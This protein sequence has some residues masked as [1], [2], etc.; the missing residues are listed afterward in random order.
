M[1]I[2][3]A[4][5]QRYQLTIGTGEDETVLYNA[6]KETAA[7]GALCIWTGRYDTH[8]G[9]KAGTIITLNPHGG[10]AF[11]AEIFGSLFGKVDGQPILVASEGIIELANLRKKA[12]ADV[13][14]AAESLEAA[15]A[16][17]RGMSDPSVIGGVGFLELVGHIIT[18]TNSFGA[19]DA[20]DV[21]KLAEAPSEPSKDAATEAA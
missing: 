6:K 5:E 21:P 9:P 7:A 3:A 4:I 19:K 12:T 2:K 15:A 16:K 11:L 13:A 10:L 1:D 20:A 18:L 8:G 17:I 14:G